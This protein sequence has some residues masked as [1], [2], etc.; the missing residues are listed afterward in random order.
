MLHAGLLKW[1]RE[2]PVMKVDTGANCSM[3]IIATMS[4][5]RRRWQTCQEDL[6]MGL[7]IGVSNTP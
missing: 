6:G 4:T 1:L 7:D 2:H 5:I 3:V